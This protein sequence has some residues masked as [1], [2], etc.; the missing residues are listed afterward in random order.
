[1]IPG[2]VLAGGASRRMGA[3]KARLPDAEGWP[4]AARVATALALGG[5][6]P[7]TVVVR[8][9]DGLGW[10]WPHDPRL[11]DPGGSLPWLA[12]GS[13]GAPHPGYGVAAALAQAR[14][15]CALVAACDLVGLTPDAVR[16]LLAVGGP[17][18]AVDAAAGRPALCAV[19]PAARAA[20]AHALAEAGAPLAALWQGLP[21]VAFPPDALTNANTPADAPP[22]SADG[23]RSWGAAARRGERLRLAARGAVDPRY[24]EDPEDADVAPPRP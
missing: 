6:S 21:T 1:V 7:V 5:C 8:R 2:F 15:P 24:T 23:L 10:W 20:A 3:D 19:L 22:A 17:A 4:W 11:P 9:G 12:D 13:V 16:S 18:V 14:A